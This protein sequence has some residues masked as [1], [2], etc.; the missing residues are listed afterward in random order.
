MRFFPALATP[1]PPF[2]PPPVGRSADF[3]YCK[4]FSPKIKEVFAELFHFF[5][6]PPQQPD[7][8]QGKPHRRLRRLGPEVPDRG[9][10]RGEA[11]ELQR[12]PADGPQQAVEPQL[13]RPPPQG[14][15]QQCQPRREAEGPVQQGGEPPPP[16]AQ[17]P[18]EVIEQR[19]PQPQQDGLAKEQQLRR[20]LD[21]HP[22]RSLRSQ[23]PPPSEGSS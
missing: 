13:P 6:P 2:A 17:G 18:E 5:K 21:P 20:Y 16:A 15:E 19:Q 10:E 12:R 9:Q 22:P 3:P 14:E 1:L 8:Q 11:G 7:R 23:P 4:P